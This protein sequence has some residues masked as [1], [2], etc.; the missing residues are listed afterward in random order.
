[1]Y[2]RRTVDYVR[3]VFFRYGRS[4]ITVF[5]FFQIKC[6]KLVKVEVVYTIKPQD[7]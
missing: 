5:T 7:I 1:M 4:V 3:S 2:V 6:S